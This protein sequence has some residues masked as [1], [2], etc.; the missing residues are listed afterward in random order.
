VSV[1]EELKAV[2]EKHGGDC[3]ILFE[4]ETPHSYRLLVQSIETKGVSPSEELTKNVENLLG[5]DS[6]FTEY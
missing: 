4:L 3:P 2:L 5:E 1:F 6:I